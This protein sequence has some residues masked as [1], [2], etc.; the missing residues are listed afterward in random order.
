MPVFDFPRKGDNAGTPPEPPDNM[1]ARVAKLE[2]RMSKI[3][4][5]I[6]RVEHSLKAEIHRAINDQTWKLIT[7]TTGLGAA[8]VTAVFFIARNVH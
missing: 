4:S 8:L 6:V 7:W 5:E 3:D 1:E 2:D